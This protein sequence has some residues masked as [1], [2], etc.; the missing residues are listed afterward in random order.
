MALSNAERQARYRARQKARAGAV[1]VVQLVGK[2]V[3]EA[4][5]ALW[6]FFNRPGP[7]GEVWDD[8]A[9]CA[10]REDYRALLASA[11]S[12]LIEACRSIAWLGEGLRDEETAAI[13][14]LIAVVD[15]L[16]MRATGKPAPATR[17]HAVTRP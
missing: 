15:L 8:I 14:R 17:L 2:S 3:E 9:G 6:N 10:S 12:G 11:P 16:E 4:V 1:D 7:G 13:A 5:D